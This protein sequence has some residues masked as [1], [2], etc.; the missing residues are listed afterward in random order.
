MKTRL[1]VVLCVMSVGVAVPASAQEWETFESP[2]DGFTAL[3]PGKPAVADSTWTSE[4]DYKLPAHIYTANRGTEKYSVTVVDYNAIEAQ[5]KERASRCVRN[6]QGEAADQC[7]GSEFGGEAH[8]KHDTRGAMLWAAY[9][10]LERDVR[11]TRYF[12][13]IQDRVEVH[14]L[15]ITNR[16]DSRTFAAIAMHQMKLYILEGTVPAGRPE[17]VLFQQSVGWLD[18][19]G[20]PIRYTGGIYINQIN[21]L[22][23]VPMPRA[24]RGR[25]GGGP[26]P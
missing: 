8:W 18:A 24:V 1:A 12:W 15:Q 10:L 25:P 3:F 21:G 20:N 9:K 4:Y 19:S 5:G 16:D 26:T 7:I 13:G 11:L 22:E 6:A 14:H 17:P 2:Q 23:K